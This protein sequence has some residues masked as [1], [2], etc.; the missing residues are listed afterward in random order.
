MNDKFV[1]DLVKVFIQLD[2]GVCLNERMKREI[3][4]IL[5][6]ATLSSSGSFVCRSQ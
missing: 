5:V 3:D 1:H 2:G 6:V 4:S